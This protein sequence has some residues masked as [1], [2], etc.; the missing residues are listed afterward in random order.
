MVV[1]DEMHVLVEVKSSVS[2]ADAV[3]LRRVGELYERVTGVKPKLALVSPYV[4]KR[5]R[6]IAKKL[7][8]EVYTSIL[9]ERLSA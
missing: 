2:A 6:E 8:M 4:E 5:A 9:G 3:E 7:G 1:R